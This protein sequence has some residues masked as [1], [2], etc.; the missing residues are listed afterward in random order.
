MYVVK[1][2]KQKSGGPEEPIYYWL[3]DV[4]RENM[5]CM[6]IR[7][8]AH[9]TMYCSCMKLESA[10]LPCRHMFAV[11]KYAN[12]KHISSGCILR[13]W[14]VGAMEHITLNED[15]FMQQE[16]YVI[17]AGHEGN[18]RQLYG[19]KD[20]KIVAAKG[21]PKGKRQ[22]TCSKC[23]NTGHTQ[24]TCPVYV[25]TKP[26][27]ISLECSPIDPLKNDSTNSR[28]AH[29]V[30]MRLQPYAYTEGELPQVEYSE[31]GAKLEKNHCIVDWLP[32]AD[33]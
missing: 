33:W 32:K 5:W 12:M 20:P 17:K 8:N 14:T 6:V 19:I 26:C 22:R 4:E 23:H 15:A 9:E 7:H 2:E 3:Q 24:R 11:M 13:Q 28:S 18:K 29:D 30:L 27:T 25:G 21:A 16:E 10:G 1:G 31:E